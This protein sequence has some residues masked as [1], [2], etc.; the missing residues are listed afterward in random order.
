[1]DGPFFSHF[2]PSIHHSAVA[3]STLVFAATQSNCLFKTN[4]K[5]S[6]ETRSCRTIYVWLFS[7]ENRT[8]NHESHFHQTHAEQKESANNQNYYSQPSV[9][10]TYP[11]HIQRWRWPLRR[12]III[13]SLGL[14]RYCFLL[15]ALSPLAVSFFFSIDFTSP[16]VKPT[17]VSLTGGC[18][19]VGWWFFSVVYSKETFLC[20]EKLD[21]F[22]VTA[23]K[24]V[25]LPFVFLLLLR[26][27]SMDKRELLY[28]L[29]VTEKSLK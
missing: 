18:G 22:D 23:Y 4:E 24:R 28:R 15:L 10:R 5:P 9:R 19:I 25:K 8:I 1:M 3:L 12:F 14:L 20:R 17:A 13:S 27:G 16:S 2:S 7:V 11:N 21:T 6:N 26:M 29:V